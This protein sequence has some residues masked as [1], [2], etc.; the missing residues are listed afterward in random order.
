MLCSFD[1][2]FG[3]EFPRAQVGSLV[4]RLSADVFVNFRQRHTLVDGTLGRWGESQISRRRI[5][6]ITFEPASQI[7]ADLR[8][9]A[10]EK[11]FAVNKI[12]RDVGVGGAGADA[13][14]ARPVLFGPPD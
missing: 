1:V 6:E 13:D 9:P 14:A 12:V 11:N 3:I 2:P 8:V 4:A 5:H 7:L 10:F